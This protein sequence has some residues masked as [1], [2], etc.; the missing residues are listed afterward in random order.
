MMKTRKNK[1]LYAA[2]TYVKKDELLSQTQITVLA[3]PPPRPDRKSFFFVQKK[4]VMRSILQIPGHLL[5]GDEGFE[6]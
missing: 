5:W 6:A 2:D 1:W 3:A 4:Y